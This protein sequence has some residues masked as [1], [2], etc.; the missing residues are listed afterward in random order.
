MNSITLIN[1]WLFD[2]LLILELV[3]VNYTFQ[4][5]C[6][7]QAIRFIVIKLFTL[8]RIYND[9]SLLILKICFLLFS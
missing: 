2:I 3:L 5:I 1:I 6:S 8:F 7:F 4:R 9:F